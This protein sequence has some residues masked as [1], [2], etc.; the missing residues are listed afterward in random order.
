MIVRCML[1]CQRRRCKERAEGKEGQSALTDWIE[2]EDRG[3]RMGRRW[4]LG[5]RRRRLASTES[6][7]A[8]RERP[9]S[10]LSSPG[11]RM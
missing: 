10:V 5:A 2:N 4:L 9:A 7:P 8:H 11:A 3:G 6:D 1:M